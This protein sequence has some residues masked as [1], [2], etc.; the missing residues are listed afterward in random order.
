MWAQQTTG[1][2]GGTVT[3]SSGAVVPNAKIT[4]TDTDK[5][6]VVRTLTTGD[7]G[8][9]Y[10]SGLPVGNYSV[11]AEASNF[12]RILQSGIVLH[13]NDR[14]TVSPVLKVGA[15]NETVNVE[16]AA[17]QVNLQS[18]TATGV[19]TGTQ[20]RELSLSNRNFLE[21]VFTVPG[22]S[23][24]GNS[25]F[26]PGAT[27]PLGTNLVTIQVNG[28]RR[29]MNNFTVDG[30]DNVDRGSNLTLLSFPSVDSIAEFRV[31]RGVY[32]AESGRTA[33]AQINAITRSGTSN[34]HGGLYEFFRN[35]KLN[36]NN[37]FNKYVV[38]PKPVV[39]RPILRYNDF[40]GTFGGPVYIPGIYK[41]RDKT[42]FFFSEEV[43][44]IITYTN[45]TGSVPYAGM[46][47]GNFNHVVCTQWANVNGAPGTCTQYG[48]SIPQSSWDPVAAAYIK[49]IFSKFPTPNAATTANPF[50]YIASLRGVFNFREEMLKIDHVF[51]PKLSVNG[52]WLRDTNPTV[53][54]YGLFN[55]GYVVDDIATTHTN[56]PG[57]Q[58][59]VSATYTPT[60]TMVIDGGYRYSYGALLNEMTGAMSA[61]RATNVVAALANKLPFANVVGRVASVGLTG[62]T[63]ANSATAPYND[64]NTNHTVHGNVAKV[65]GTH[66]VKFGAIYY[67]YNKH[68]NQLGGSNNGAFSF[69]SPTGITPT[70]TTV[71][72]GG[73]VCTGTAAAGG[74][75]PF[76]YEQAYAN[77][78]LG[79]LSSFTQ[80]SLD[81]TAN[82]FANQFEYYGQD[83]WRVRP[84]L[85]VTYGVRHSFFRQPT[86]ASG[87]NGTSR[88]VNFDPAAYDPAKAPCVTSTGLI[89]V[90][91]VNGLPSKSVC[92]PNWTPLNGLIFVDPPTYAGFTGAKSPY[93]SKVG[94]EFNRAIAPRVGIAWD[95]WGD[96][97]TSIRA[98]YGMFFDNGLEFGNP[99]INVGLNQGF[100]TTFTQARTTFANPQGSGG[101]ATTVTNITPYTVQARMPVNYKSPY[102]Q[103]WSLDIQRMFPGNWFL[104]IGYFGNNGIHLP[105]YTE[106]NQPPAFA[107]RKCTTATPCFA[108]PGSTNA[109]SFTATCPDGATTC[110]NGTTPTNKL[111]ALRP[112]TGYGPINNFQ[113]IYTSNYHSLQLQV[114]KH[115]SHNSMFGF[116]YTWSHG[117]TTNGADRSTG[118]GF[119][120]QVPN[121]FENNYG[122][123][124]ADRRHIAT[125]NFVY[126]LPW[127]R[128]QK[129]VIGHVLGGWQFSGVVT[130]QTGLPLTANIGNAGCTFGSGPNCVDP[131]GSACFGATFVGC[132][133]NQVG[134][135]N[136]NAP[137]TITSWFN[138]S[139]FVV[140][141]ATQDYIPTER[142]GA[143]RGPGFWN[144]D[145]SL[146]KN[147]KFTE[148]FSGQFRLET[149]N[150]F[151]HTNP[152]C[153]ASTT[154]T[155][156]AFNTIN[157]T[158]DPRIVQLAIKLNF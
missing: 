7:A 158:R 65:F 81:V 9:Y 89:D 79:Q 67:H 72:N 15:S 136:Q 80:G 14:L 25:S 39:K 104:D 44:R 129:G 126:E 49:D 120:P 50:N 145:V 101:V 5:K 24:S 11:A 88:L 91:T 45:P 46:V 64:F 21:L 8:E 4:I 52:K 63:G 90:V 152:I 156:T 42:F 157:S 53:E 59:H 70:A 111:N 17:Q 134:D 133:V 123:T 3:D 6:V 13:V 47:N 117:L 108:G 41:Q 18:A 71:F 110:I 83:T 78:L 28:G 62:G 22:T 1:S 87:A 19:V 99:E 55:G 69:D 98:G 26:F 103:Q 119:L 38:A 135:P 139:A 114:N 31:V 107:Y 43:R 154:F 115:F 112:F 105:G 73:P 141:T 51:S 151:N 128:E 57:K 122:P 102:T 74:T 94:K 61:S 143:I 142:P 144:A 20:I 92:N 58:Y 113:D 29:E 77:F 54:P 118:S 68:E 35:D 75:C 33:G 56:S 95:P 132:R 60:S 40:G 2:I 66:T 121:A 155:S 12:Q 106:L 36:A 10:A 30:A 85:T 27:A 130:F 84:N 150:T 127:M 86:D 137:H 131:L 140:P 138:P 97:K 37:F 146:F 147:L 32:E 149:F 48:T 148:A 93:G 153:C 23:N 124:V 125:A 16:A 34:F 116:V 76:S 82:I 100:L 96:G 109:V